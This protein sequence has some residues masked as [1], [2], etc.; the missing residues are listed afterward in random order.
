MLLIHPIVEA[1]RSSPALLGLLVAGSSNGHGSRWSLI[2][3]AVVIALATSRWFTTRYRITPSQIELRRGLFR[4]RTITAPL[5]R[6]RTVDVTAH[7]LHRALGLAKV[8]IG[9][10]TSDRRGA[11]GL[12][13]DGL[14]RGAADRLRSELLHQ[15]VAEP[16]ADPNPAEPDVEL[17]HFDRRWV[18]YA[19]FTLSGAVTAVA[20]AGFGWRI[21]N[22]TRYNV[23]DFGPVHTAAE[24][25]RRT[26]IGVDIVEVAA[27]AFV[28]IALASTVGYILAF[29]NFRL[30]RQAR[31]SLHI[32]RGLLTTRA[33]TIERRR[34]VGIEISEPLLLRAVRGARCL[35]IATGLRV[36]RGAERGGTILLPPAPR[37]EARRV[38]AFVLETAAPLAAPLVPHGPRARRRRYLRAVAG[39]IAIVLAVAGVAL[40]T[41]AGWSAVVA[42]SLVIPAA[43][44]LAGDRYR[45][46]G[47]AVVGEFLTSRSGSLVR[48]QAVLE[49]DDIIGWNIRRTLMQ[50]RAG[51]ATLV[52]T[53]AAG[54]QRYRVIDLGTATALA[55]SRTAT[56]GLLDEFATADDRAEPTR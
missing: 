11:G 25:L 35:A 34:L 16:M 32:T 19:P 7:P 37:D 8:V 47:H 43:I 42:S 12:E 39:S 38:A 56:P 33:T 21:D 27:G 2:G 1:G 46:L 44:L 22:E 14:D 54:R 23:D 51:L 49:C 5:D 41:A 45:N 3:V 29:W 15:R 10:G 6:V 28:L 4:R 26:P 13:L 17:T 36:G 20:V 18:R 55:L 9:T 31:H 40:S 53:T 50:R 48:R 30:V 24:Q 52:A